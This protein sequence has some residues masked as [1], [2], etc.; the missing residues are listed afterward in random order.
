MNYGFCGLDEV[1]SGSVDNEKFSCALYRHVTKRLW[2]QIQ[3][4]RD[5]SLLEIGT[6]RGGG[7]QFIAQ[8][9]PLQSVVAV[10]FCKTNIRFCKKHHRLSNLSFAV[11]NAE[12]LSFEDESFD[13]ALNVE[14]SHCYSSMQRFNAGVYR[15]L[16]RGGTFF[17]ADIRDQ[18]EISELEASFSKAGFK[19]AEREIITP[20]VVRALELD[21]GRR[22]SIIERELPRRFHE[23]LKNFSGVVGSEIYNSLKSGE[24]EYVHYVLLKA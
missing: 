21:S 3:D 22:S 7:A 18:E 12:D 6:G 9:L 8:Q 11:G 24:T 4:I 1:P 10:D 14:S 20:Q 2:E 23:V 13:F 17:F 5:R 15:T 16:K 19:T